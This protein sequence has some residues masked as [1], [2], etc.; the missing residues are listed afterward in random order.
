MSAERI[1]FRF[2][3]REHDLHVVRPRDG[4]GPHP[5][6]LVFHAWGGR[7][8]FEE[9]RA[10]MLAELGYIGIAVDLFG[11]GRRGHDRPS[12]QAL[13]GELIGDPQRFRALLPA[14]V[15]A[16]RQVPGVDPQ[17]LGAIGYCFGGL[18]VLLAARLGLPLR[19]VVSFHGL[20]KLGAPTPGPVKA[21]IMVQ[22]GQADPMV[23][24][25]DL[26]AFAD[27]MKRLGADW[28]LHAYPGV[29]HAFTNPAA[30]DPDFGT[31]YDADADARSWREALGFLRESVSRAPRL[32]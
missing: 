16:A 25:Q 24:D 2:Q 1:P 26:H 19:A 22:H 11:V 6:V 12:C 30:A 4:D 10:Q 28:T 3:E 20:L 13:M 27:E 32:R 17:R 21:R 14:V 29:M 31:V 18:S 23:S 8:A 7:K 15:Q 5:A 9:E